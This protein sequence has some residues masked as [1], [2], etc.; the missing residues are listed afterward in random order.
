MFFFSGELCHLVALHRSFFPY[1]DVIMK[2]TNQTAE[3]LKSLNFDNIK[4]IQYIEPIVWNI[5]RD[6]N[7]LRFQ[8]DWRDP[9]QP[10]EENT[11]TYR[12]ETNDWIYVSGMY[13]DGR[14]GSKQFLQYDH[15]FPKTLC[16]AMNKIDPNSVAYK[17]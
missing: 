6:G 9:L 8:V 2:N 1:D 10:P 17:K 16:R 12:P 7:T 5:E 11:L 4:V 15:E 3:Y 13:P 14:I